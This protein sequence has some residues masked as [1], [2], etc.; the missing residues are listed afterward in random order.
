MP[1]QPKLTYG[2]DMP[3][4]A[5]ARQTNATISN[6]WDLVICG[7]GDTM[8]MSFTF[9]KARELTCRLNKRE[10]RQ[11]DQSNL[12]LRREGGGEE[13]QALSSRR[14]DTLVKDQC[15]QRS[16]ILCLTSPL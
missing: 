1:S 16:F 9:E 7:P 4:E 6:S 10:Y 2:G 14:T 3:T 15:L 8:V 5:R 12:L 11:P 13:E